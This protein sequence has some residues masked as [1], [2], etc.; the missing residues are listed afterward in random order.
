MSENS[1]QTMSLENQV[2]FLEAKI[3]ELEL[4]LSRIENPVTNA[5]PATLTKSASV[6]NKQ[7]SI[8]IL[9]KNFHQADYSAGDAGDRIDFIFQF[10]NHLRKDIRAFTGIIVF[11][12]LFEKII[13]KD[14]VYR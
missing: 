11:K 14:G 9:N 12:D 4:R 13:F 3:K 5:T 2:S 8:T 1:P 6:S 7:I 10:T